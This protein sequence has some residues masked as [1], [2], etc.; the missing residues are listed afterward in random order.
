MQSIIS[1]GINQWVAII[2]DSVSSLRGIVT[3]VASM[4][5][6]IDTSWLAFGYAIFVIIFTVITTIILAPLQATWRK[7]LSDNSTE[8]SKY[9]IRFL[10]SKTEILQNGKYSVEMQ[11]FAGFQTEAEKII[12]RMYLYFFPLF[13][14]PGFLVDIIRFLIPVFAIYAI[15][16]GEISL[17]DIVLLMGM[18]GVI[19]SVLQA[20][21][22]TYRSTIENFADVEKMRNTFDEAPHI[23]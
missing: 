1:S 8:Q 10:M 4:F 17:P 6:L 9:T 12:K 23:K 11:R 19:D 18:A 22:V 20:I 16:G 7:K 5:L 21:T 15:R 2:G 3:L 13:E 14:V